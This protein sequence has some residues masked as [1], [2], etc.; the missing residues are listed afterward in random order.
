[1][2]SKRSLRLVAVYPGDVEV[3]MGLLKDAISDVNGNLDASIRQS[4]PQNGF[5]RSLFRVI[6]SSMIP[7]FSP[8]VTAW[9]RSFA[10]SLRRMFLTRLLTVSSVIES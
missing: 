10:T 8:I 5:A 9:V 7:R 6:Y 2:K 3:E 4:K 1:M